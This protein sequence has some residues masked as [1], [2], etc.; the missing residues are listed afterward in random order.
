MGNPQINL[1]GA[2]FQTQF[3]DAVVLLCIGR[4]AMSLEMETLGLPKYIFDYTVE[5]IQQPNGIYIVTGPTGSGKTTTLYSCLR[6]VNT[7]DSKLLTAEDPVEY[8][9]EGIMQV[10][11]NEAMGLTF[12]NALRSFLR[13]AADIIML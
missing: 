1:L 12:G 4:A 13:Q 7:M 11:V 10:A 6:K 8:D 9:I 2:P 3:V 5:A